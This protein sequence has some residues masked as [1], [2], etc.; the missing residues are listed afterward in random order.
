MV[1]SARVSWVQHMRAWATSV[2]IAAA[3]YPAALAAQSASTA[4]TDAGDASAI[5]LIGAAALYA[6]RTIW[7]LIQFRGQDR[8]TMVA[9]PSVAKLIVDLSSHIQ[10]E[11]KAI[12]RIEAGIDLLRDATVR[13]H[14]QC[15]ANGRAIERLNQQVEQMQMIVQRCMQSQSTSQQWRK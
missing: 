12:T 4:S 14:T 13:S 3:A 6:A 1:Q 15:E 7:E 8:S 9:D 10:Q 2:V 5:A 11:D